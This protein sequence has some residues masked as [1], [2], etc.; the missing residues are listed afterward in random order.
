MERGDLVR[1]ASIVILLTSLILTGGATDGIAQE[2]LGDLTELSLEELMNIEITSVLKASGKLSE[3]AAAIT[4]IKR[5]D[6]RR[7]GFT[8]IPEALRM[9]AEVRR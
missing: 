6:I 3:A 2:F 4:V 7:F 1:R 9:G 5:E 8:S